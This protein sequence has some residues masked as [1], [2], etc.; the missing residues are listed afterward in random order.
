[1]CLIVFAWKL[2]PSMPLIVAGNRDEFYDRPAA[3][4][5]WWENAPRVY[6]GRD[7]QA[8]GTW[9]G[10]TSEDGPGSA[11]AKFAAITN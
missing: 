1:M 3:P 2:I 9:M 4:A 11:T 8:G 7:L 10:I 6:A 5:A